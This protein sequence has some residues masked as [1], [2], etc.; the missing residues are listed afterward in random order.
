MKKIIFTSPDGGLSVVHPCLGDQRADET[1]AAF[2]SRV[3][4]K[5]VP[6]DALTV[7]VVDFS[8]IPSDRSFRDAWKDIG[9]AVAVD[10]PKAREI[11]REKLRR[12]RKP[13]MEAL[14]VEALRNLG[15]ALKLAEIEAKKQELRDAT[16]FPA[17][18]SAATPD[19]LKLAVPSCLA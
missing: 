19:A 18:D 15:S 14:D 12:L 9:R 10:M 17:I 1:D 4:S 13:K 16:A 7:R 2:L 11:H 5:A 8:E 6:A 3:M